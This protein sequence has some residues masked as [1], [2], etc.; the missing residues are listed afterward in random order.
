MNSLTRRQ[1]V[2]RSTVAAGTT[3]IL[4]FPFVA[5]VLGANDR[6]N[7][8]CI[9]VGGKGGGNRLFFKMPGA[10]ADGIV[11]VGLNGGAIIATT[12]AAAL[13]PAEL[14]LPGED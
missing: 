4:A 12:A 10:A 1:F 11:S 8:A 6:V 9:G 7:D 14:K 13:H 5:R 2:R 3:A